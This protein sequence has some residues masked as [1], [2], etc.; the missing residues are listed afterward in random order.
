V[1]PHYVGSNWSN[2]RMDGTKVGLVR[3]GARLLTGHLQGRGDCFGKIL[4]SND[5]HAVKGAADALVAIG[6]TLLLD[7]V[8]RSGA[9]AQAVL[10][11]LVP[12]IEVHA[13]A[14][15]VQEVMNLLLRIHAGQPAG[16]VRVGA[17]CVG[18]VAERI[19][20]ALAGIIALADGV[21][22][23]RIVA[24]ITK[25]VRTDPGSLEM[26]DPE[27][28]HH[29]G[30][31]AAADPALQRTRV[32][33]LNAL[34]TATRLSAM[35]LGRLGEQRSSANDLSGEALVFVTVADV[36]FAAQ[37]LAL[38]A[39]NLLEL[40][41]YYP[42]SALSRQLV[43]FEYLLWAFADE[44][45]SIGDWSASD[46]EARELNWSPRAIYR[47]DG[48]EFRRSDYS[49]HCE[50]GG[51]PTPLG[52]RLGL[53]PADGDASIFALQLSDLIIHMSSIWESLESL[54]TKLAQAHGFDVDDVADPGDRAQA[55]QKVQQWRSL[56]RLGHIAS[57]YA[58]PT[59]RIV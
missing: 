52:V 28:L 32:D 41:N 31:A 43:E 20:A 56:D 6:A 50:Q 21:H 34:L 45:G 48:S 47:R 7:Q 16:T 12:G 35:R 36:A 44:P 26:T 2:T 58:D 3:D 10:A 38:G 33:A 59:G 18:I 4:A 14:A 22:P 9:P 23:N 30:V 53:P 51:H 40:E 8:R 27:L 55:R 11:E 54:L 46:R 37:Q 29:A 24:Q 19:A 1:D 17:E 42:A 39:A 25:Q 57:H 13:D 15:R 49:R 5:R